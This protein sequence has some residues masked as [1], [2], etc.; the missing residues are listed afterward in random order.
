LPIPYRSTNHAQRIEIIQR[1]Q[2]GQSYHAIAQAVG[3]N[4][5][6]VRKWCRRHQRENWR[7]IEPRLVPGRGALSR[8]HPLVKY[9]LLKLK[10][11]HPGWGVDKLRLEMQRRPALTRLPLVQRS[12]LHTYLCLF[13]PRL[14]P[15]RTSI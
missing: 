9:A 13:Y 14:R 6:T 15:Y 1:H 5:Y 2:H 4:Y 3:L 10:R 8:F 11:Q 7:G 12:T